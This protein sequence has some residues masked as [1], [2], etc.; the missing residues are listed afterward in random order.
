[1]INNIL[2]IDSVWLSYKHIKILQN[3]YLQCQ[4]GQVVGLLGSNGAGKSSLL[5][6]MLGIKTPT[7][8]DTL[9]GTEINKCVRINSNYVDLPYQEKGF[10]NYL[11]QHQFI[12]KNFKVSKALT[13]F[14][15]DLDTLLPYFPEMIDLLPLQ[16]GEL[17]GGQ[18]RWIETLLILKAQT[19]FSV[20]DEPFTHI[21]PV[22]VEKLKQIIKI[23][24]QNKGIIV[25][26]HLYR[27]IIEISDLLYFLKNGRTITIKN[28][29]ELAYL[30]Y[31]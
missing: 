8:I 31:L 20:L 9:E 29:E 6:I 5:Q 11:P 3:I 1:L 25:T 2:E 13:W 12:P 14:G 23:E 26:D 21:S 27:H 30:G 17:S 4:T 19:K 18:C 22:Q 15:V 10:I 28:A 7:W 16:F 24:K